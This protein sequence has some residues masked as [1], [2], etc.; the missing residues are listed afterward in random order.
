MEMTGANSVEY[1]DAVGFITRNK[2][3][4]LTIASLKDCPV[5]QSGLT[6]TSATMEIQAGNSS[7]ALMTYRCKNSGMKGN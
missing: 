3:V 6:L 4:I 5:R 2:A 7:T 1:F